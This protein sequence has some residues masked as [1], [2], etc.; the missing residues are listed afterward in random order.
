MVYVLS[1]LLVTVGV[2][3]VCLVI[4]MM[5]LDVL[6]P[7]RHRHRKC[8]APKRTFRQTLGN[9]P[10]GLTVSITLSTLTVAVW[11]LYSALQPVSVSTPTPAPP[12]AV[13][14][15]L[16][17]WSDDRNVGARGMPGPSGPDAY[18][19]DPQPKPRLGGFR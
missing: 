3:F 10:R 4:V 5:T 19:P 8:A 11:A 13:Q 7:D 15:D 14:S 17:Q 18:Q 12:E 9:L 2:V 1:Y 6:W 16:R